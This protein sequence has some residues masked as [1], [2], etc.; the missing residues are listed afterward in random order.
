MAET[1]H[2][3]VRNGQFVEAR[4]QDAAYVPQH[5]LDTDGGLLCRP[6]IDTA[7][8]E[9]EPTLERAASTLVVSVAQVTRVWSVERLPL[10]E[11]LA[12][13]KNECGA[14]IYGPFPQ[15]KQANYTARATELVLAKT[16]GPLSGD[17]TAELAALQT[18]WAWIKSVRVASNAL[19]AMDPIPTDYRDASHWPA[20]WED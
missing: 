4:M 13:V 1:L 2:A 5:K 6:F 7:A 9:H 14:R 20:A 12:A 8:P 11:Q 19:E 17:E 10:A 18:A 15:W 3:I 16:S